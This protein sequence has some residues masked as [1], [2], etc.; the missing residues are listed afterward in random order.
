AF[1]NEGFIWG[2][3]WGLYDNMHF[4]YRPELHEINRLLAARRG[5]S[6]AGGAEDLRPGE[7]AGKA[8]GRDLHHVYPGDLKKPWR[9]PD[10]GEFLRKFLYTGKKDK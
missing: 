9:P 6:L 5:P 10:I 4:E 8:A 3:K 1:E 2:G 7:T